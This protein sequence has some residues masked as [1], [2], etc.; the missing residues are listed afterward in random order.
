LD[1]RKN[2]L[3]DWAKEPIQA[4][5]YLDSK[6]DELGIDRYTFLGGN[7]PQIYGWTKHSPDGPYFFQY[8]I[9]FRDI[10]GCGDSIVSS[11]NRAKVVVKTHGWDKI[12]GNEIAPWV[13]QT[14]DE[15]FTQEHVNGYKI[16]F[17]K[18]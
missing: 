1:K 2:E 6:M 7:G 18:K 13:N 9:W 15:H 14:L 12:G 11:V 16:Y 17:R 8:D 5:T 4:A 10:P 3:S